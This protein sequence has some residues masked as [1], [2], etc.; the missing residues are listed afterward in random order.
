MEATLHT[1]SYLCKCSLPNQHKSPVGHGTVVLSSIKRNAFG[2]GTRRLEV[3]NDFQLVDLF[4]P[5]QRSFGFDVLEE[6]SL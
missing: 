3:L 2:I 1:G 5:V 6:V 4:V